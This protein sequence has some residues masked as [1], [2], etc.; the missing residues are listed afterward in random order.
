[1]SLFSRIVRDAGLVFIMT[2]ALG[3]HLPR[4]QALALVGLY[5]VLLTLS[6]WED[7]R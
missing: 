3:T 7:E 4:G 6:T 1:M 5:V 2:F